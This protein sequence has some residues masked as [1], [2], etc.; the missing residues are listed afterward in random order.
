MSQRTEEPRA[1]TAEE[2]R[3]AFLQQ[4]AGLAR[5]WAS[6]PNKT[7]AEAVDGVVFSIL[8]LLDGGSGGMPAHN[9]IP[10]PHPEDK[11]FHISEG[12]NWVPA[13]V[14]INECQLHELWCASHTILRKRE[15]L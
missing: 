3:N 10:A 15:P 6:L 8:V 1:K 13:G 2:M 12:E 7:K 5:Y 11:D 14:V 9:V 4:I